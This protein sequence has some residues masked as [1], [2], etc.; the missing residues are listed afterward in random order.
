MDKGENQR[1]YDSTVS[2]LYY[3]TL[4]DD[5]DVNVQAKGL[6]MLTKAV[7]ERKLSSGDSITDMNEALTLLEECQTRPG[8]YGT[9]VGAECET[10]QESAIKLKTQWEMGE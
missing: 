2:G 1:A 9:H 4:C 8:F 7:S 3:V 10:L 5:D 6:L